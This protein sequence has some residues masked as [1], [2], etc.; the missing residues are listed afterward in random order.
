MIISELI[1]ELERLKLKHG[2]IPVCISNKLFGG[3]K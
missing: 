1:I 3:K 2:D